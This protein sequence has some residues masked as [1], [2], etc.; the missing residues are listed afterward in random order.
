MQVTSVLKWRQRFVFTSGRC[1]RN[2][3]QS[4]WLTKSNCHTDWSICFKY[5]KGGL[6]K[7]NTSKGQLIT[8]IPCLQGTS[9]VV[10]PANLQNISKYIQ[11][12]FFS[13]TGFVHLSCFF[14]RDALLNCNSFKVLTGWWSM[15]MGLFR[16][17]LEIKRRLIWII[18]K[19]VHFISYLIL[20]AFLESRRKTDFKRKKKESFILQ[21]N[22]PHNSSAYFPQ[23]IKVLLL[24]Y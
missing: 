5:I 21:I 8:K 14:K 3:L 11:E 18:L 13:N 17:L 22:A 4:F 15:M 12:K 10:I 16:Y 9:S 23:C 1:C 7:E 2:C 19:S 24:N 6:K 20:F